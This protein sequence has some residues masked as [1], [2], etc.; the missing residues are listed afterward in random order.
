MLQCPC[1]KRRVHTRPKPSSFC[2]PVGKLVGRSVCTLGNAN[3][4]VLLHRLSLRSV[5]SLAKGKRICQQHCPLGVGN[6]YRRLPADDVLERPDCVRHRDHGVESGA[7]RVQGPEGCAGWAGVPHSHRRGGL[8]C[9]GVLALSLRRQQ[10]G[11]ELRRWEQPCC[12]AAAVFRGG[13]G[14]VCLTHHP[15]PQT[16][17]CSTCRR[18]NGGSPSSSASIWPRASVPAR[19]AQRRPAQPPPPPPP[20]PPSHVD[21]PPGY[22][23]RQH[24]PSRSR[25]RRRAASS[26][27]S[28]HTCSAELLCDTAGSS[29]YSLTLLAP[30]P[31]DPAETGLSQSDGGS[32]K[33]LHRHRLLLMRWARDFFSM[34]LCSVCCGSLRRMGLRRQGRRCVLRQRPRA[35]H[36]QVSSRTTPQ[37][38]HAKTMASCQ[39]TNAAASSVCTVTMTLQA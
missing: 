19:I 34:R 26:L 27:W 39:Q 13:V 20:P 24:G 32:T 11:A 6:G 9:W 14:S 10:R 22:R 12:Y 18:G 3:T 7:R 16:C 15:S 35:G 17:G 25:R 33:R 21:W 31:S 1:C 38:A 4:L 5:C 37:A 23:R 29:I 30:S 28:E 8:G 36:C 2:K